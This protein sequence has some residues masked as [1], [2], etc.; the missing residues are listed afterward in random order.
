MRQTEPMSEAT[1]YPA[2]TP[3]ESP[4]PALEVL[5][6][7]AL[8]DARRAELAALQES[9]R[10][11]K[12]RYASTVGSRLA[13]LAELEQAIREAE[14]RTLG[15][16]AEEEDAHDTTATDAPAAHTV[17]ASLRGLFWAVAKL[18]HPDRASDEAEARRRHAIMA[19]ASRAYQAGDV[20]SLNTL[21][22]DED[23]QLYCATPRAADDAELDL[24]ARVVQLRE[25]L[26]TIEFG[27][28]RA[29]QDRLYR[30]KLETDEAAARGRDQL[31]AEAERLDRKLVKTRNRLAHLS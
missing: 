30:L 29:K 9:L 20:E 6:L 19:E 27:I 16:E 3:K 28:T 4:D 13:E 10:D 26:L 11:F 2:A 1:Q 31:A 15:V 12:T 22:G 23:L 7:S 14:A 18:F 8:L 25:E 17:K 21:L 5:R 24:A